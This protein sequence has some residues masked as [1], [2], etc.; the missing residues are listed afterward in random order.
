[1]A[2]YDMNYYTDCSA[3]HLVVCHNVMHFPSVRVMTSQLF[4]NI[5]EL[6]QINNCTNS[7]WVHAAFEFLV[8]LS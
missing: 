6:D 5:G 2:V 3:Y 7:N 1:M 4:Q 8:P